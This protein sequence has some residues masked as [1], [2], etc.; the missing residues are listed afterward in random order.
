MSKKATKKKAI[1][2][3]SV[4]KKP[5]KAPAKSSAK[6]SIKKAPK[7][8]AAKPA[9]VAP[10][11]VTVTT[12][13]ETAEPKK[14]AVTTA[15]VAAEPKKA[16]VTSAKEASEPKKA[17]VTAAPQAAEAAEP[18]Q[19]ERTWVVWQD[20]R[21][22]WV[23]TPEEFKQSKRPDTI[24][25]DV[26]DNGVHRDFSALQRAIHLG[27]VLRQ[28]YANCV[29]PWLQ[30]DDLAQQQRMKEWEERMRFSQ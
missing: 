5:V 16:P 8:P 14:A 30:Y 4:K 23:G 6:P 11:K 17:T 15:K 1:K 21:G 2:K 27:Q 18:V 25:C 20:G 19:P 10:K 28:T 9:K 26:L 3:K 29:K 7:K 13:R 12:P 22:I 24:V